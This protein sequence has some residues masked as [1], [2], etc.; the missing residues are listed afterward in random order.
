[1]EAIKLSAKADADGILRLNVPVDITVEYE[2]TIQPK[3]DQLGWPVGYFEQTAGSIPDF[4]I[5]PRDD[6]IVEELQTP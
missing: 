1:M 3:V 4:S 6:G 2:V 5:E